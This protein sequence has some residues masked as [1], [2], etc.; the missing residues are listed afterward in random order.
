MVCG[1]GELWVEEEEEEGQTAL[2]LPQP[3]LYRVDWVY[4][5]PV[6]AAEDASSRYFA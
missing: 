5:H 2:A 3:A 1:A 4:R 6:S